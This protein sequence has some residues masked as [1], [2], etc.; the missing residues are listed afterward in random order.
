ML[1]DLIGTHDI[2]FLTLDTLRY[3]VAERALTENRTPHLANFLP[4]G[5]WERRHSPA[6]FTYA[7]HHAFFGGFLPTPEEP[8]EHPRLWATRFAG[9]R[10]TNAATLVFD[11]PDIVS[12]FAGLGYRTICIGGTGFFNK[13]SALGNVLPN[14]FEESHWSPRLS[15]TN[16]HSTEN[17]ISLAQERLA[18]LAPDRR[19]FLFINV[20][21]L[22][23]PNAM[24][25]PGTRRDTPES[26][27]AAL[28]YVDSCL[29]PLFE[30]MQKRAPIFVVICSDHGTAYGED[31]YSG[32]RI[33]HSVVWT[34]PYAQFILPKLAG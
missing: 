22:H 28:E 31:G 8:G 21:A 13:Q 27:L 4:G 5:R 6:S 17:Q 1:R 11:T 9:S 15:V 29:P 3:D 25:L 10:T 32:H 30:T 33:G 24:Y 2:L 23:A 12:G 14:L 26:Q 18:L 7:A 16:P 34:V 20:S 19:V